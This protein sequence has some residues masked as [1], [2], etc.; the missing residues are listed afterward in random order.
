[1]EVFNMATL[2]GNSSK[3]NN[4]EEVTKAIEAAEEDN[5]RQLEGDI[6]IGEDGCVHDEPLLAGYVDEDGNLHKTF[7]YRE[8]TGKDEEAISRNDVKANG[9]KLVNVLCERCVTEIGSLKK[10]EVGSSKWGE[11]I[12]SMLGADLDY[13][14][15]KIRELSKGKEVEF[16]HKCPNCGAKLITIVQTDEFEIKPF[17]GQSVLPF[18]LGHNGYKDKK[19]VIHREGVIR[20]AN[21]FDREIVT[22]MFKKNASTATSLLLS[23]L[24]KFNDGALVTQ[25]GI[26]DMSLRDRGILEDLLRDNVFG[27]DTSTEIM[28]ETCGT[29]LSGE[30]GTSNFF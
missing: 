3:K 14:A 15:L 30:V 13:M 8:M 27:I 12:R 28:C 1:M 7:T 2:K 21:G 19:G 6:E 11:I 18:T 29:D 25:Q 5:V 9:A 24:V 26:T 23:R 22:P 4:M 17:G 16:S 20:L 10:K